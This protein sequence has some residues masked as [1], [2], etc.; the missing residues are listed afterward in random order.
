MSV[1]KPEQMSQAFVAA[2][3]AGNVPELLSLYEPN[4]SY[5]QGSKTLT[6]S[7]AIREALTHA[8][9]VR[10][11]MELTNEYC[12]VY[13]DIA[14]VRARWKMQWRD[15]VQVHIK[16]GHSSEVLR[17]GKDGMWRYVID[18]PTGGD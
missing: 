18:H 1:Q 6:G 9:A 4:A 17:R 11:K 12:V 13:D 3:N 16:H 2:F 10:P 14:L 8:T 5:V 7:E 15:A